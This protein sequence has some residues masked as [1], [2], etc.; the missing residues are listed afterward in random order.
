ML[1]SESASA[2][3]IVGVADDLLSAL[4]GGGG[5]LPRARSVVLIVI[6]GLGAIDLRAHA[7]HARTLTSA[8]TKKSVAT[9]VFPTT[10]AA[11]LTSLLTGA[12]PGVHGLVGYR[13]LDPARDV[14]VN[15]LSGWETEGVDPTAW[16]VAP[17]IFERATAAG[18]GA[19][20]VGLAAYAHSGFSRATLRGAEFSSAGAAGRP[21]TTWRARTRARSSTATCPRSIR[22]DIGT[23][24]RRRS[25][26]VPWKR[27]TRPSGHRCPRTWVCW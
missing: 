2:R 24:S 27:S 5:A 15:Q 25:G 23:V 12:W 9:S 22:P 3:S 7:G 11:A 16:Q 6:D 18:H 10:T 17:T 20:A 19:F 1:P 14:L 21:P 26:P 4:D 8:M 13:V